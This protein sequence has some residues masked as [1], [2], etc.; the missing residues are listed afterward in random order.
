MTIRKYIRIN[1]LKLKAKGLYTSY[2]HMLEKYDCGNNLSEYINPDIVKT[3]DE[4]DAVMKNLKEL[5]PKYPVFK[6]D[7]ED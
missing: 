6:L 7:K 3:K 1:A 2:H 5:D 4:F